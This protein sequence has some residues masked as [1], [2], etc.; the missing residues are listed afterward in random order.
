MRRILSIDIIGEQTLPGLQPI[1]ICHR[2]LL[3]PLNIL[4]LPKEEQHLLMLQPIVSWQGR[5]ELGICRQRRLWS[6]TLQVLTACLLV[7][8]LEAVYP[9]MM[10][11]SG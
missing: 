2:K 6:C 9:M 3:V 8:V 10:I 5:M 1:S 11:I 7:I 4:K